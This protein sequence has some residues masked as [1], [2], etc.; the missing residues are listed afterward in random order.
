MPPPHLTAIVMAVVSIG[1]NELLFRY[2]HCVGTQLRSQTVLANAW[3]NRADSFSSLAVIVGVIGAQ[4]GFNHL[5]PIAAL[6][7]AAIIIRVC[8]GNIKDS[9]AGL[10]DRSAPTE[11]LKAMKQAVRG[12]SDVGNINYLHARLLG[13]KIWVD[14]GVEISSGRTV[15]ECEAIRAVL[16]RLV[17][18]S[19]DG[20]GRVQ[21]SF[22]SAAKA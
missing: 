20:V 10:M 19:V 13:N 5:D 6:L 12:V 7:V 1:T 18:E 21:V 15:D 14:L 11:T 8:G 16:E 2:F 3:A 4:L 17:F 9:V 22:D